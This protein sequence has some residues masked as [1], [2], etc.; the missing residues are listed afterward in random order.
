MEKRR[1]KAM[2]FTPIDKSNLNKLAEYYKQCTYRIS[3]YSAG[4]KIMWQNSEYAYAEA[5]GCLL[6]KSRW[7]GQDYFD[8]PVPSGENADIRGALRRHAENTV[9][10]H[11][12]P[13]RLQRRAR[14]CRLYGFELLSK[15]RKFA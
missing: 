13:F 14:L 4:I 1:R 2:Q 11:F 9:R 5:C 15:H 10:K 8:Y 12:I 7:Y 6:V 3:D